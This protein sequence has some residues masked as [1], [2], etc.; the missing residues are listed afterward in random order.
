[1]FVKR[2]AQIDKDMFQE[3]GGKG[4][5]L[6]E[7][8]RAG[9]RVPSGFVVMG[10]AYYHHL[11]QNNLES[12]IREISSDIDF[13]DYE[14]LDVK[15]KAIRQLIGDA[16]IPK[17]IEREVVEQYGDMFPGERGGFVAVRSSVAIKDSAVSSFPGLM[18]TFHYLKG[19]E[20]V[21]TAVRRVWSSVWSARAAFT[22]HNKGLDHWKAV[23]APVV[24]KMVN[25]DKAGVAFTVNPMNGSRD[26]VM[27]EANFGLGE[28]VVSGQCLT[29]L[30][31]T[32][33]GAFEIRSRNISVKE[34]CFVQ[35][36]EGGAGWVELD[37]QR[38]AQPCLSDY[39]VERV[40]DLAVR[41]EDH[42]GYPQDIEWAFEGDTLV[43][44]QA[45]RAKVAGE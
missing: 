36:P 32:T 31:V 3:A 18:D 7:M 41:V 26:E 4:A 40:R 27:I 17:D 1:M 37:A 2:F 34:K 16:P 14:D 42:Y 35:R 6:G 9:L 15:T 44:L 23:I 45:R 20:E 25:S 21:L 24:Q 10:N 29:D 38:G 11:E 5:H 43:L 22:R 30:F 39:E 12:K 19:A 8:T 13:D 28:G 33:K